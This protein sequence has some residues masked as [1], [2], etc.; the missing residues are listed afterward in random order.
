MSTSKYLQKLRFDPRLKNSYFA[1]F[2]SNFRLVTLIIIAVIAFGASAY[3]SLP[4]K[5]NPTINIPLVIV[6]TVL[7]GGSPTD[8]E[9][10]VSVHIEDA[11]GGLDGVKETNSTSRDSVSIVTIEFESGTDPEKAKSDVESAVKSI[12]N[13]PDDALDPQV[14]KLD[15]ENQPI[16]TFNLVSENNDRSSLIRFA[17]NLKNDLEELPSIDRVEI[18]GIDDQ[19]IQVILK[20]E[21]ISS[22]RIN[23]LQLTGVIK[24]SL[25]SF[26]AGVVKT[27]NSVFSLTIDQS[28][29]DINDIR[30]LKISLDGDIA[31]LGDIAEI[32][33]VSKPDQ[34]QSYV[35]TKGVVKPSVSFNVFRITTQ[36]IEAATKDAVNLVDEKTHDN[37]KF[38]VKTVSNAS[39]ILSDEF[40]NLIRDVIITIIL[41]FGVLLVFLGIRQAFISMLSVPFT[42]LITF[43]VMQLTG[44]EFSFLATF[45]LLLSLGL[46]VDD[47]I[48]V[49][50]AMTSYYRTKKFSPFETA[51]LVFRDFKIAILTTTITTVWAFV[52]LILGTGIIGEFIKPIPIVV[53]SALLGSLF[54]AFFITIP[55]MVFI[56]K[57]TVSLR[58]KIFFIVL[59][60]I[61]VLLGL[62]T[63]VLPQS[64]IVLIEILAIIFF[65]FVTYKLWGVLYP[66]VRGNFS[67]LFIKNVNYTHALNE[68][69]LNFKV[70]EKRYHSALEKILTSKI[71]RRNTV[72]FVGI[73]LLF[74]FL[75]L[76]LGFVKSEFFPKTDEDNLYISIE[77]PTGTNAQT[78]QKESLKFF[79]SLKEL[80]DTEFVTLETGQGFS[81]GQ[82]GGGSSSNSVLYSI[83][84]KKNRSKSSSEIASNLRNKFV[85][86]DGGKVAV[87]EVSGGPPA[88]ADLQIK[89]FGPDLTVLDRYA[90]KIQQYL[91]T[92]EGIT[93]IDRSIKPGTSKLVFVPD[94]A[95]L[96]ANNITLDQLGIWLRIFASGFE[97]DTLKV[98]D[99]TDLTQDITL[100]L[101]GSTQ[102]IEDIS[103]IAIPTQNGTILLASLGTLELQS[104]PTLITRENGKR[105]LSVTAG[106]IAGNNIAQKNSLL[107]K[108][109]D[110][111]DLPTGYGW[112]TGG[113]NEENQKS[114]NSILQAML[115]SFL[116][117]IATLVLQFSS[118]RRAL[119]VMLVIPLSITGVLIIFA[120]T[121]TPLSFPALI[122]ILALFG[123]V[124]KNSILIVDKILTNQA[125]GMPFIDA[126][127]EAST[128]RLEPIALT[129]IATIVG[130]IPITLS[131]PLWRGLGGSIIAG[132]AFSG[133]IMLF[134]IPVV[135]YMMYSRYHKRE[136]GKNS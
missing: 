41:V 53:S 84:L 98:L 71:A 91:A 94:Q 106:V 43:F 123:I 72:L 110:S 101:G 9:S 49:I 40:G 126:I 133:T 115:Y 86:Y 131:D 13:L 50:S 26:P 31:S 78:V 27:Q 122:G 80:S 5:L 17:R 52:P 19:E 51:L 105:T 75:L 59:L 24:S 57:P 107:E 25:S 136:I 74:A 104:N 65:G 73:F 20:P 10:L 99:E 34:N 114:V 1:K 90:D 33:E 116:L 3:V 109:A 93:N 128:S 44:I 37:L 103:R 63:F 15:F 6:S 16:W 119:I 47:T 120:L 111:L 39:E 69:L 82:G 121:N 118:F 42:F 81:S 76:P 22:Y 88:G 129:S 23:P 108:Y 87:N 85:N 64:N 12:R 60:F 67:L 55:L 18:T 97:A 92:Q 21:V 117:I 28:T 132:L 62:F 113:V 32:K 83:A 36:N 127:V 124:V 45:S 102:Q 68:G 130:L 58:V 2:L 61:T 46:L 112:A 4:R 8:I 29:F 11:V 125:S 14:N 30:N 7:P 35:L 77:F 48:V 70:V 66:K 100:R 96:A 134:F 95:K 56:L 54:V 135:Y 89:L 79:S 38:S